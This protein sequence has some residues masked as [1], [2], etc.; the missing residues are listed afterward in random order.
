MGMFNIGGKE[1][2]S[3]TTNQTTNNY[4]DKSANA[5]GDGSIALAEGSSVS[6]QNLDEAVAKDAIAAGVNQTYRAFDTADKALASGVAQTAYTVNALSSLAES[7][8]RENADTRNAANVAVQTTAGLVS[9]LQTG[10]ATNFGTSQ[11]PA[12]ASLMDSM[13]PLFY[14][15]GA[16]L[17]VA[18]VMFSKKAS[19]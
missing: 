18:L 19:K 9:A 12:S 10:T 17:L 4:T 7:S 3:E 5:G 8:A 2:K 15:I 13:K 11:Q 14:V 6:I 1:T 16:V